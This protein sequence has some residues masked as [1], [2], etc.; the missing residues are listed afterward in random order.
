M[1]VKQPRRNQV[2]WPA[3]GFPRYGKL[4]RNF[5]TQW[6]KCFHSVENLVLGLFSG[7][8]ER[9]A[10]RPLSTVERARPSG[11]ENGDPR[12]RSAPSAARTFFWPR[13]R[14]SD[15]RFRPADSGYR[16]NIRAVDWNR[17]HYSLSVNLRAL[18]ERNPIP[19]IE[20]TKEHRGSSSPLGNC[21]WNRHRRGI[22]AR[23]LILCST[24]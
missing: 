2:S 7:A 22:L 12:R 21:I 17:A 16:L 14:D 18:C 8:V 1:H 6:K 19:L 15:S 5:S 10:R 3:L 11:R 9:S 24:C 23:I 4:F 13:G 20:F